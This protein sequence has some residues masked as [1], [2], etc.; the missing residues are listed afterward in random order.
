MDAP[1]STRLFDVEIS[2]LGMDSTLDRMQEQARLRR[3]GYACFVNTHVLTESTENRALFESLQASTLSNPDGKP[4][5]WASHLKGRPVQSQ[6]AGPDFMHAFLSQGKPSVQGLIGGVSTQVREIEKKYG[7]RLI[8][9]APPF[10]DFSTE[11]AREDWMNFLK[12]CGSEGA[13]A[14]VWVGLGAPKQEL[15]MHEISPRAPHTLFFGVGAA[16]DFLSGQKKRA[17]RWMRK[18]GLEWFF[19]LLQ[20][21]KRLSGRYFY[22][23]LKFLQ[24][25]RK[26]LKR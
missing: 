24:L 12:V 26:D 5:V 10:R 22:Y 9:Y 17:P 11:N 18:L 3:G 8:R 13:P 20:E 21:P 15:W 16:I 25:L 4:L 14:V 1:E 2:R 7:I 19:R 23:N 6:V